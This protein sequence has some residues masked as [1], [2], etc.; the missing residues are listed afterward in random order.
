[1]TIHTMNK[2]AITIFTVT[3]MLTSCE[4]LVRTQHD[5]PKLTFYNEDGSA[6]SDTTVEADGMTR[7]KI[8]ACVER[9]MAPGQIIKFTTSAGSLHKLDDT[10][11]TSTAKTITIESQGKEASVI[12]RSSRIPQPHVLVGATLNGFTTHWSTSFTPVCQEELLAELS[13]AKVSL[14]SNM[15]VQLAITLLADPGHRVS[16]S[17]RVDLSTADELVAVNKTEYS[18]DGKVT[19]TLTPM[20]TGDVTFRATIVT[21]PCAET[22]ELPVTLVIEP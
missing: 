9:E 16:D 5:A 12:L 4:E 10:E 2:I 8:T 13:M 17:I 20:N 18:E 3:V 1:M 14:E 6:R 21:L 15:Q 19:F 7:I 22:V 11:F